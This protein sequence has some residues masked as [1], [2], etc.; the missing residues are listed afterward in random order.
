MRICMGRDPAPPYLENACP[1]WPIPPPEGACIQPSPYPDR[2]IPRDFFL[3]MLSELE[4]VYMAF[5][6][7]AV[8]AFLVTAVICYRHYL[9]ARVEREGD[10]KLSS[11]DQRNTK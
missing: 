2:E 10:L 1:F 5:S 4:W 8:V 9:L 3:D 7:F 6:V 11:T